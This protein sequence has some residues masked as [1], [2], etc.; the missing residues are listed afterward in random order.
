VFAFADTDAT[1]ERAAA[2]MRAAFLDAAGLDSECFV[3]PVNSA[4][5]RRVDQQP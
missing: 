1:A 2:A 3:G 4:G 5:A